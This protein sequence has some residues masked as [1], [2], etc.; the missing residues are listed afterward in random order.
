MKGQILC[1]FI[2][3]RPLE[4]ASHTETEVEERLPGAGGVE[5]GGPCFIST[6]FPFGRVKSVPTWTAVTVAHLCDYA[7]GH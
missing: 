1:G 3:T 4:Q 2:Y 7:R 6:A 5:D